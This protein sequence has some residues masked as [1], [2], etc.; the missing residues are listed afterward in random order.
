MVVLLPQPIC[1]V[2]FISDQGR[3]LA[4]IQG[5]L[6]GNVL[7]RREQYR[8]A[9]DLDISAKISM[10]VLTGKLSNS[11]TVLRRALRDHPDKCNTDDVRLASQLLKDALNCLQAESSLDV[12]RGIEG[13]AARTYY[14]VFDNLI[15]N[16]K[17]D[18]VFRW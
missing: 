7:L 9:D 13:D 14:Q 15:T 17:N 2:S 5:P 11:R 6:S 4:R 12:L 18:F 8:R 16:Q 10:A 1:P 3:F